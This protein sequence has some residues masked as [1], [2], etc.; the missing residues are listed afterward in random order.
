MSAV[1]YFG[2]TRELQPTKTITRNKLLAVRS[3][4]CCKPEIGGSVFYNVRKTN[5]LLHVRT[6][7]L[8]QLVSQYMWGTGGQMIFTRAGTRFDIPM[9]RVFI[10]SR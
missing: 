7:D 5:L 1:T 8:S 3:K 4:Q 9:L 10:S 6:A 2:Q